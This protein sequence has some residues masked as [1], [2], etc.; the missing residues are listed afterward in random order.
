MFCRTRVAG[1]GCS[2]YSQFRNSRL[3]SRWSCLPRTLKC[4]QF[5]HRLESRLKQ[6]LP[7]KASAAQLIISYLVGNEAC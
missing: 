5:H 7:K 4:S 6:H 1:F 3:A 2:L